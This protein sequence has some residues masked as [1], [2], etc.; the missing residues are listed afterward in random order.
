LAA[1][2]IGHGG[3]ARIYPVITDPK[4]AAK[5]YHKPTAIQAQKLAVMI[6]HLGAITTSSHQ[7]I[8]WPLDSLVTDDKKAKIAGF[9]MWRATGVLPIHNFYTPQSRRLVCP[10]FNYRYLHRVAWNVAAVIHAAQQRGCVIGD[11]N[12]CFALVGNTALVT[13]VDAD[14]FQIRDPRTGRV[15]RCGV[16]KPDF[17][18]PELQ[19]KDFRTTDRT[20][21]HDNFGLA[22]L[23]FRLLMEGTHP[24]DGKYEGT[25]DPP[26]LESRI[27]AGHFPHGQ[28]RV[29]WSPKPAAP[30]FA[31][32]YPTLQQLLIRCF[33]HGHRDP[34]ARPAAQTLMRTVREAEGAL[35]ECKQNPQHIFGNHLGVC[36]WCKR[37]ALLGGLDPFPQAGNSHP[38]RCPRPARRRIARASGTSRVPQYCF[39]QPLF[40]GSSR[41]PV[42]FIIFLAIIGLMLLPAKT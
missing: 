1:K 21:A 30:P 22:V 5:V 36:P 39:A 6:A 28:K 24:F 15:Y 2:S 27:A 29:P 41:P 3:E 40:G 11:I 32:L 20:V 33:E 23:I 12:E 17:T 19:G 13:V 26:D 42:G 18:P 34:N 10:L 37:K 8:A 4:L 9:L 35:V 31:I 25:G 7:M 14:S 16:G 38:Q